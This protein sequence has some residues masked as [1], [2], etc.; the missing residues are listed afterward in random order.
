MQ[1]GCPKEIK[2][3]EFRV[4]LMPSAVF[5]LTERGHQ[6]VMETNAGTGAGFSDE[7]YTAAGAEIVA[8]AKEVF[9][10]ANMIV[11]VKEPQSSERAMLREGQLL[12]TYREPACLC[13]KIRICHRM[14]SKYSWP[15]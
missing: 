4:G 2:P 3:Q 9:D 8:T 6:V 15:N 5:E 11:K 12:F 10:R 1:I 13:G 14:W 7:D